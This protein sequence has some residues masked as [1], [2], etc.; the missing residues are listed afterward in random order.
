MANSL[1]GTPIVGQYFYQTGDF[2]DHEEEELVVDDKGIRFIKHC[3]LWIWLPQT[4]KV[5]W[6]NFVDKDG[7]ERDIF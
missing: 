7:V 3:S 4:Q 5:W 1:P 2:G 6:Q